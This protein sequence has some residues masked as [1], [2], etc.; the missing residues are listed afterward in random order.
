MTKGNVEFYA[1]SNEA[2]SDKIDPL[3]QKLLSFFQLGFKYYN[4]ALLTSNVECYH[5]GIL[6]DNCAQF[7]VARLA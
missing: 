5:V 7:V 1:L 3:V 4:C 2:Q 6:D